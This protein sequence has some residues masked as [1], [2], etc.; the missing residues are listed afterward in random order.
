[1]FSLRER[2]GSDSITVGEQSLG[3]GDLFDRWGSRRFEGRSVKMWGEW[4]A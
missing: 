4:T 1:M 3:C 2:V